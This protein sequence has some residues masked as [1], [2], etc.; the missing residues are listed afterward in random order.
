MSSAGAIRAGGAFVEIFANDSKFQQAMTR[1]RNTVSSVAQTLQRVGTGMSLGGAGLSAPLV[2]AGQ[3]A[4]GF[5]DAILGMQAAAGLSA[6]QIAALSAKAKQFADS[7]GVS[8][9]KV[10][11]AFLELARAGTTAEDI[12]N[13]V[14][15]AAV[16]FSR[17]SGVE[18]Q[19]AATFMG[20]SMSLFG[21][22]AN[23]AV[24]TLSA[25]N[26]ASR[27]TMPGL[28]ESFAQ[29]GTTAASFGQSLFDVGQALGVLADKGIVGE[30]AGTALKTMLTKLVNPT[31]DATE[32]L[33]GLGLSIADFRD[34]SGQMLS[35]TQIAGVFEKA[36]NNM[37][38]DALG[39]IS[40]QQKLVDV[41]EQR[42]IKVITAFSEAGEAGFAQ[43][44]DRMLDSLSVA[45]KFAIMMSGISGNIEKLRASVERMSIAFGEAVS[46]PLKDA[47]ASLQV[48]MAVARQLI[49]DF[50]VISASAASI[51]AGMIAVGT[52][53]IAAAL[54]MRAFAGV[55]MVVQA[56][57]GPRGWIGLAVVAL[58][59]LAGYM[60][61]AFDEV[62][63]SVEKA[64]AEIEQLNNEADKPQKENSV[65]RGEAR[66]PLDPAV[67]ARRKAQEELAKEDAAFAEGQDKAILSLQEMSNSVADKVAD[68]IGKVADSV[69]QGIEGLSDAAFNAGVNFQTDIAGIADQVKAGILNPEA[70]KVLA[71]RAK[72]EFDATMDAINKAQE[73]IRQ[74]FGQSLGTFG[75]GG[76]LGIGPQLAETFREVQVDLKKRESRQGGEGAANME[77]GSGNQPNPDWLRRRNQAMS[78]LE[79]AA[80]STRSGEA[81]ASGIAKLLDKATEQTKAI[82]EQTP[83]LKKIADGV[84]NGGLVFA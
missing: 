39:V 53:S 76:G 43:M 64:R 82:T 18:M 80:S 56:L 60:T 5:E 67:F 13:G 28:V 1:V 23:E 68:T 65:N 25:V 6:D 21:V 84:A 72:A 26:D 54:A 12:L 48:M 73:P 24:D 8:P 62:A 42:G 15:K 14:G 74:D 35:N 50:P 4:A 63:K 77:G 2:L 29:V 37:G 71:E 3:Q 75:N 57:S 69:A 83:L 7:M 20:T 34:E 11:Q 55:S 10:A 61:G 30:E 47:T 31:D 17:V 36:I 52:A 79:S 78:G 46:G 9:T 59:G 27:A 32:A 38:G 81:V 40:S 66:K 70:A 49:E 33:N 16:Q 22:S 45:D 44:G 19:A 41:F 58:G 51:A